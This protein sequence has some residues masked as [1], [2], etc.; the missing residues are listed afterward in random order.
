MFENWGG[1]EW[2]SAIFR[3]APAEGRHTTARE[4]AEPSKIGERGLWFS[5]GRG[6]RRSTGRQP[7][8]VQ[9]FLY[10]G[11]ILDRGKN[12]G[13]SPAAGA[14]Q[15]V[16]LEDP[17]QKLGPPVISWTDVG[18]VFSSVGRVP[19]GW[20]FGRRNWND[21]CPMFGRSGENPEVTDRMESGR[22]H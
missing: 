15:D 17:G 21:R 19:A 13:P 7:E 20:F 1:L 16:D 4:T 12:A 10:D 8:A 3:S 9:D 2:G 6:H 18:F 5:P 11:G 22:R 14:F